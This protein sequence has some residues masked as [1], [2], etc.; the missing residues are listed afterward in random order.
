MYDKG[1]S[2]SI[3]AKVSATGGTGELLNEGLGSLGENL[4]MLEGIGDGFGGACGVGWAGVLR[5]GA[6]VM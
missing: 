3:D 5:E 6:R 4:D 2:G 1:A